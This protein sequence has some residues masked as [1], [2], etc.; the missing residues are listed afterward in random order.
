M[1][2]KLEKQGHYELFK[3]TKGHQILNLNNKNWFAVVK[4]QKGDMLI[5][6]DSDHQKEKTI[7]EGRFYL[8]DFDNDPEFRDIPHLFLEEGKKYR[9]WLLPNDSPT[10][11]DY[12]KK[13]IKTNSLV[14]KEKVEQHVKGKGAKGSE[15]QY[16]G[17]PESLRSKSKTELYEVA[18]KEQIPGRSK[19]NKTQLAEK[20]QKGH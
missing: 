4:G 15:K 7:K 9:E 12:Q 14:S 5:G 2:G 1:R 11:K 8:A 3:T 16:E 17:R 13:L 19:M 6:S 18:K 10:E 20:L